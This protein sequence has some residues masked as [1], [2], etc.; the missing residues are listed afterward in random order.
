MIT[1]Q[2]LFLP[3]E[4]LLEIILQKYFI[5]SYC[6]TVVSEEP[7]NFKTLIPFITLMPNETNFVELL[8]DA[9]DKGCSDYVVKMKNAQEFMTAFEKVSHLGLLRRSDRKILILPHSEEN[10]VQDKDTIL[11]VLSMD[12]T[13]FVTNILLLIGATPFMKDNSCIVY[14]LAT[15]QYVGSED[16]RKPIYLDHWNSCT[17][18][19]YNA[20]LFPHYNMSNLYGKTLKLACFNY[21]PYSFLDLD[22]S[23]EPLGRDGMEVRV[24]D[25]FC[26][27][28]N[29]TIEIVRDDNQWGEIYSYENLTGVGVIGNVVKDEA[30]VGISAL[31]SWYEEYVALDFTAP[32]VRTVVTCIAPAARLLASWELP[33]LPFSFYMWLGLGF[34]FLYSSL[35]LMIAKGFS[36][37][38]IFLT[39]FGMMITQSQHDAGSTWRIRSVTGWLLITGLVLDNAYGSGLASTFTV[40]KYEQSIDTVQDI[41][42]RNMEWGATHD[43]WIFS[44]ILSPE[45]LVKK[46]VSQFRIYS[47]EE[48]K[49]KSFTREMAFSIEKLPAGYFAIGDYITKEAVDNLEIMVENFYYEQCVA[50][51][52]KSSPYTEKITA[53]VGRLHE[54]GLML[55]WET[56]VA[57][58]H[59]D[60][61]IQIEVKLSRSRREVDTIEPLSFRNVIG[62]F[63]IYVA[64]TIISALVFFGEVIKIKKF[65]NW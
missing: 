28:V 29:C 15:H 13:R 45:P 6:I 27:W 3:I 60:Y 35:A 33:L 44:M 41:V 52:R 9:S 22:I 11:K 55:A 58:K 38:K 54:S 5:H 4:I 47:A 2:I 16:V 64:G 53:L 32:L 10:D 63:I 59:L 25:E 37:D 42:D 19:T 49:R 31:Y 14:D 7:L 12:E 51:L 1:S 26:R 8:L 39:T 24:M 62:I 46:L 48:L 30:D 17:G 61:K 18:F 56:Q 20:N 23:L 50:M 36:T 57:L 65:K 21:K 43:A 40:P 34:T